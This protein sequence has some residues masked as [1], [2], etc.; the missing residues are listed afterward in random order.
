MTNYRNNN[1]ELSD[2]TRVIK[3]LLHNCMTLGGKNDIE[4]LKHNI[5]FDII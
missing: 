1:H 5:I 3:A 2:S 4:Q